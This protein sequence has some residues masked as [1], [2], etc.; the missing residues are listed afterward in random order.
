ME[1]RRC[2]SS[3][4]ALE[5]AYHSKELYLFSPWISDVALLNN[6]FG[7]LRAVI[8]ELEST[9]VRLSTILNLLSE[10]NVMI[11]LLTRA[12]DRRNV[13]DFERKL[14]PT[15][16]V[17]HSPNLHEKGLIT[18]RIFVSGSMNF[19]YSGVNINA[20]RVIITDESDKVA[21]ALIEARAHWEGIAQGAE[22][23]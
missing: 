20:E 16:Q 15:I 12:Q 8:P 10:R 19:T 11:R 18:N 3:T 6:A 23:L 9:S 17:Q 5:L 2:L 14:A 22:S 7:Q 21:S 13:D 4:L 1:L